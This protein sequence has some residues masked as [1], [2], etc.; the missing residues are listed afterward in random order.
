[1]KLYLMHVL[2]NIAKLSKRNIYFFMYIF[3]RRH[4]IIIKFAIDKYLIFKIRKWIP[5]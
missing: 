1:M 4:Y 3:T 2:N 5:N